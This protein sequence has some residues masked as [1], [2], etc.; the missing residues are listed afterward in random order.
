MTDIRP[1]VMDL[2]LLDGTVTGA[3]HLTLRNREGM[4]F[5]I[6]RSRAAKFLPT[7]PDKGSETC[8]D[9]ACVYILFGEDD[10]D[11]PMVYIGQ[12]DCDIAVRLA[13]HRVSKDFW[14]YAVVFCR[15]DT[16]FSKTHI[17][18]IETRLIEIATQ[19]GRYQI[20]NKPITQN[21]HINEHN[22]IV[23][24]DF[25]ES[26][27]LLAG[28]L[29]YPLFEPLRAVI[30]PLITTPSETPD[31]FV[32]TKGGTLDAK[33]QPTSE[34]FVVFE[35][36]TISPTVT[37]SIPASTKRL[38]EELT[39]QGVIADNRFTRDHLFNTPS[40]AAA[41]IC[42]ASVNGLEW[43]GIPNDD[44]TYKTLKAYNTERDSAAISLISGDGADE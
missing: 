20:A 15:N 21:P 31:V 8:R 36:S 11:R 7:L 13:N 44:G 18:Y 39:E 27:K 17:Y 24:D 37:E 29:G 4:A 1:I 32:I 41:V 33:G 35:K 9:K 34:G 42:G 28:T 12:S 2:C 5:K 3:I 23:A 38:R 14:K 16:D 25:I 40:A 10:K 26:I 19:M 30:P 22:R 6:P 43:W